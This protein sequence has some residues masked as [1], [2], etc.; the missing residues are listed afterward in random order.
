MSHQGSRL[1]PGTGKST[2]PTISVLADSD[3]KRVS[4]LKRINKYSLKYFNMEFICQ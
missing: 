4:I 2:K 3:D 1:T